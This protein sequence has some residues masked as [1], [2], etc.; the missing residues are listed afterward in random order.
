MRA[1]LKIAALICMLL[2][3]VATYA[4]EQSPPA[5]TPPAPTPPTR[6][7]E[8]YGKEEFSPFL[9]ALRRGEIILF[10][11]LPISLF[12][13]FEAYDLGRFLIND[14]RLEYA[15]WPFRPPNAAQYS[16]EETIG[17]LVT[18]VSVSLV[19]A[20]A[21]YVVGRIVAK[22]AARRSNQGR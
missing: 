7:P 14:R 15:P 21:D 10:G 2:S 4:Q 22:R 13:T 20:V 9:K 17:I 5:Q 16:K 12:L 6:T 11:S 18:A 1:T 8:E 19:L 3:A